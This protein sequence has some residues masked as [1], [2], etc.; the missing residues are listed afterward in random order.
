MPNRLRVFSGRIAGPRGIY[1]AS[2]SCHPEPIRR[3]SAKDLNVNPL[4]NE[5]L[6]KF[7]ESS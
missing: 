1:V 4:P 7:S 5:A 3:G 6:I 2:N